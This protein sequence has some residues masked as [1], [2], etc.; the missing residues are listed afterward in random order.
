MC[1]VLLYE[2]QTRDIRVTI[3]AYFNKGKLVVEGYD[4]GKTVEES[5]GDSDYEYS[6]TIHPEEVKKLYTL[7]KVREGDKYQLLFALQRRFN[8]NSCYSEFCDFLLKNNIKSE[9]FSW[10]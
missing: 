8:T 10:T 5:W 7:F 6:T 4:I 2:F 9:G 1:R 3:E